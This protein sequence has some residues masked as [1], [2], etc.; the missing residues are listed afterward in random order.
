VRARALQRAASPR[1][2]TPTAAAR[3]EQ[4]LILFGE[5][6]ASRRLWV[7][8]VSLLEPLD[9]K[10]HELMSKGHTLRAAELYGRAAEKARALGVDNFVT[11]F[12]QSRASL[13]VRMY[14]AAL[15]LTTTADF[16]KARCT[17]YRTWLA[18]A[19]A[20]L[21]RRHAAGTLLGAACRPG[22]KA[23]FSCAVTSMESE[24][25]W[26]AAQ[27]KTRAESVGY[28]N[29]MAVAAAALPVLTAAD[30]F[31]PC[32]VAA[33]WHDFTLHVV[34]AA[35][36]LRLPRPHDMNV[37]STA[38]TCFLDKFEG[39]TAVKAAAQGLDPALAQQLAAAWQRLDASGVLQTRRSIVDPEKL[40]NSAPGLRN[41]VTQCAAAPGLR[42]CALGGCGAKEAHPSHFKSC[43]A[44]KTVCYCCK[45]HQVEDW[46]AHKAA[47][48][49]ARSAAAAGQAASSG[50]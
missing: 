13:A 1:A 38:E 42:T 31:A 29:C 30:I 16:F 37:A 20:S 25:G 28:E 23:W 10:A 36:L 44:C 27:I 2:D 14:F 8:A 22:E 48:K 47:C 40:N 34:R 3:L 11:V 26:T 15:P 17:D 35:D 50:A 12:Y 21:E 41:L 46:P 19:V 24:L 9:D 6:E 5:P 39:N 43:G 18:S 32:C 7:E 49:E 45:E 33:D 4:Q